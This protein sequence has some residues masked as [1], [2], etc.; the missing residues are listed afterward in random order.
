[1]FNLHLT[2]EPVL[3]SKARTLGSLINDPLERTKIDPDWFLSMLD[4][5]DLANLSGKFPEIDNWN[6]LYIKWVQEPENSWFEDCLFYPCNYKKFTSSKTLTFHWKEILFANSSMMAADFTITDSTFKYSNTLADQIIQCIKDVLKSNKSDQEKEDAIK[7][8]FQEA[9]NLFDNMETG[10]YTKN[11]I[12]KIINDIMVTWM[13]E[14]A[15]KQ[16]QE[17]RRRMK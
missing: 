9:V 3:E 14:I 5:F 4:E 15:K 10:S 2:F 12:K 13:K 6:E 11:G 8:L 7:E 16:K 17:I 1:M